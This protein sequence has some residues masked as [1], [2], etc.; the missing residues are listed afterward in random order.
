MWYHIPHG[1][2]CSAPHCS[3]KWGAQRVGQ[4]TAGA[5]AADRK[6]WTSAGTVKAAYTGRVLQQAVGQALGVPTCTRAEP[7]QVGKGCG[8]GFLQAEGLSG[9][10]KPPRFG[11]RGRTIVPAGKEEPLASRFCAAVSP[12]HSSPQPAPG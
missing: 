5:A 3:P 2:A 7:R 8:R 6:H 4:A 10:A 11:C 9:S 1:P 12:S